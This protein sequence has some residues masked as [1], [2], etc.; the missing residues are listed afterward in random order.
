MRTLP[1]FIGLVLLIAI[2]SA[3]PTTG[4][5]SLISSNNVTLTSTAATSAT[6]FEYGMTSGYLTWKTP[7]FT[8]TGADTYWVHGSPLM[9]GQIY[10]WRA[11]DVTGCGV[12]KTFTLATA[13]LAPQPTFGYVYQNVTESG[14]DPAIVAYDAVQPYFWV[15]PQPVV[16]GLL[17]MFIFMAL[18][19]RGRDT[20]VPAILGLIVGFM[21][22]N[23]TYGVQLPGEFIGLSQGLA[24]ASLAGIVMGIFKK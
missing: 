23:P 2:V 19:I 12:E 11:C 17:F 7:N 4:S 9:A 24:Y 20:T 16:W 10:Y 15:A 3:V 1:L 6:W 14:F 21:V 13:T 8:A 5:S 18:W 22:F